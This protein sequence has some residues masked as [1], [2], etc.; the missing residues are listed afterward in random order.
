MNIKESLV[1]LAHRWYALGL[2]VNCSGNF[3]VR[4][5]IH[6]RDGFW[7][8]PTGMPYERLTQDDFVWIALD[9][10]EPQCIGT[11]RPSS[12]W[13]MHQRAYRAQVDANAV[14]HTHSMY[15]T[16]LAC[17]DRGIPSFH[18][19]VAKAGA[20]RIPCLPY[21]TFGTKELA[22]TVRDGL[23]GVK[24]ALLSHHG[25]IVA[26][27]NLEKAIRLA[28]EVEFLA[29]Q[30]ILVCQLGGPKLI[31]RDEMQR[32][33]TKFATYGQQNPKEE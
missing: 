13:M 8:T 33:V 4:E 28:V 2:G 5:T 18:Y 29:Q 22:Q 27:K 32:I 21:A 11:R 31:T 30:Y 7:I 23:S 10:N 24:A 20:V 3:S 14:I 9:A 16:A 19:M 6:G 12:E 17:C 26:E 15:A 25:V 1:A